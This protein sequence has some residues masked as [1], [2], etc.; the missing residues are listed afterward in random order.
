MA[1]LHSYAQIS[2]TSPCKSWGILEIRCP[3]LEHRKIQNQFRAYKGQ[4]GA[5]YSWNNCYWVEEKDFSVCY[6]TSMLRLD[7]KLKHVQVFESD[8][9]MIVVI[10]KFIQKNVY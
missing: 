2:K 1:K 10:G 5:K 6:L 7:M 8:L 9:T 3:G 4:I